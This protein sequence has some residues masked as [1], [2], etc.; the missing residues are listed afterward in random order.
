M[1]T[2]FI[3]GRLTPIARYWICPFCRTRISVPRRG[4]NARAA[5]AKLQGLANRHLAER[6]PA[7][8][9]EPDNDDWDL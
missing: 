9:S 2:I 1:R 7:E 8:A 5:C 3:T 6:H 4:I